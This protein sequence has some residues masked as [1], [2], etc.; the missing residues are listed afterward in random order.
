[1]R[2]SEDD[3]RRFAEW[4]G[5]R[6]PLHT[7]AAFARSTPFGQPIAHGMLSVLD[8]LNV[9]LRPSDRPPASLEIEFRGA[10][11][12][13][14]EYDVDSEWSGD[15]LTV[16]VHLADTAVMNIRAAMDP[17]EG[18]APDPDASWVTGIATRVATPS[19]DTRR[20]P[21]AR[22]TTE[23]EQG[24]EIVAAYQTGSAAGIP[25]AGTHHGVGEVLALC[26][27]IVGME[28][29][30]LR[31]LFTRASIRF[32]QPAG[33]NDLDPPQAGVLWYRARTRRFDRHFRILDTQVDIATADA[34]PVATAL[35]RSYVPFGP[36]TVD[37]ETLSAH[38]LPA[39][40]RLD[41]LV[42]LVCGGSRSLGA[43]IAA[44]LALSGC[45]VYTGAR[46]NADD[47]F[48]LSQRLAK[49]GRHIEFVQGDA[50]DPVW[51]QRTLERIRARHG[52]LDLLVLNACSAP[53]VLRIGPD[54]SARHDEYVQQNLRLVQ[55]P[56]AACLSTLDQ[57]EGTVAYVSSSFVEDPPPGLSHYVAL[58]QAAEPVQ[59]PEY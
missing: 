3:L 52:R 39:A 34:R 22:A 41:G 26:S 31:S 4:S 35:L 2:F 9:A 43:D 44:A 30:G 28:L 14:V 57:S 19:A 23:L 51:C 11:V 20:E 54:A 55:T 16:A 46:G 45:H 48:D 7:D 24:V 42:A 40:G 49:R 17:A 5:D 25:Y 53:S 13:G 56:L 21:V 6:N 32:A 33:P 47:I 29:P 27:Y 38:L 12:P 59:R 58:K 36:A 1:M 8:A 15:E 37:L 50:G 18:A 10:V